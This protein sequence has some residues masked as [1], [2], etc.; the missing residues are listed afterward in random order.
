MRNALPPRSSQRPP[1]DPVSPEGLNRHVILDALER[2]A[3]F[4]KRGALFLAATVIA[5]IVL[6]ALTPR[7]YESTA[8]LLVKRSR[9]N[10]ALTPNEANP[11]VLGEVREADVNSE[12]QILRSTDL[13]EDVLRRMNALPEEEAERTKNIGWLLGSLDVQAVPRSNVIQVS[14]Q[15]DEPQEAR[16]VVHHLTEAYIDRRTAMHQGGEALAFFEEQLAGAQQRL[17]RARVNL[18]SRAGERGVEDLLDGSDE[19]PLGAESE[20]SRERLTRF[21]ADLANAMVEEREASERVASLRT[22]FARE[23][24][25][26][27]SSN[28]QFQGSAAVEDLERAVTALELERDDLLQRYTPTSQRVQQIDVQIASARERLSNA[29]NSAGEFAGTEPNP[30]YNTLKLELQR[31]QTELQ[32]IRGR[33]RALE[34]GIA[35]E[36]QEF[37][38][39]SES[40]LDLVGLQKEMAAAEQQVALFQEKVDEARVGSAMDRERMVNVSLVR[41]PRLPVRPVSPRPMLN[42]A[43]A[44]L[45]GG[46]GGLVIAYLSA[47]LAPTI[48]TRTDIERDLDLPMIAAV[49]DHS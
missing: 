17:D 4:W 40:S 1:Y 31:A 28:R 29:R 20:S 25:R 19:R 36:R 3:R 39:L 34:Q 49:V 47:L 22:E 16:D 32:A 13:L 2:V 6:T 18:R 48:A 46:M 15:S 27:A 21:R 44:I 38:V 35:R 10:V 5:A 8:A 12:V 7:S 9:A 45:I 30:I 41:A 11:L 24:E 33:R 42:L 37:A 23:P 26:I 43:L 14:Y